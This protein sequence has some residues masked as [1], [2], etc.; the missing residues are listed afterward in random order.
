MN[1]Q[2]V[3]FEMQYKQLLEEFGAPKGVNLMVWNRKQIE[4]WRRLVAKKA[5]PARPKDKKDIDLFMKFA[6]LFNEYYHENKKY[7]N[8]T[9]MADSLRVKI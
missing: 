1:L 3:L 9:H 8:I 4:L 6:K 7:I 2:D 5:V